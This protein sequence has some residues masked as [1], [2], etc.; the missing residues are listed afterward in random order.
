MGKRWIRRQHSSSPLPTPVFAHGMEPPPSRPPLGWGCSRAGWGLRRELTSSIPFPKLYPLGEP[1]SN[2]KQNIQSLRLWDWPL[3]RPQLDPRQSK[4]PPCR[5][6][7]SQA[8]ALRNAAMWSFPWPGPCHNESFL[9]AEL[10]SLLFPLKDLF[11][12]PTFR[13]TS[14]AQEKISKQ[15][16]LEWPS[17]GTKS[18]G[19]SCV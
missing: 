10:F 15:P 17:V 3:E 12:M 19:V 14:F 9:P 11:H 7:L 18:N 2:L 16:G 6:S 13:E 5:F 4:Q 1:S 8:F